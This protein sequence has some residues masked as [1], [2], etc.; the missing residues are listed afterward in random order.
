MRKYLYALLCATFVF[1]QAS[2]GSSSGDSEDDES[3]FELIDR[4]TLNKKVK[5]M[6]E[7]CPIDL[8]SLGKMEGVYIDDDN[9]IMRLVVSK[10]AGLNINAMRNNEEQFKN[11]FITGF[12]NSEDSR[13][14]MKVIVDANAGFT[15]RFIQ[16]D[17]LDSIDFRLSTDDLKE[18][19]NSADMTGSPMKIIETMANNA[20]VQCPQPIDDVTVMTKVSLEDNYLTYYY[21]I[22]ESQVSIDALNE[23]KAAMK[24]EIARNLLAD[25]PTLEQIRKNCIN[26]NVGIRYIYVGTSSKKQ[27]IIV[28]ESSEL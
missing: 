20:N 21:D 28:F 17:A 15:I 24:A 4:I 22:D 14:L 2:C 1:T 27:M 6:N 3:G 7:E 11:G 25:D 16:A 19:L 10:G 26:A 18:A 12:S 13:I 5:E 23:S 9:V 8:G